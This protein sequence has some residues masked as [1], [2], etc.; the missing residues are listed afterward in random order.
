MSLFE[1]SCVYIRIKFIAPYK[2]WYFFQCKF[3]SVTFACI[4]IKKKRNSIVNFPFTAPIKWTGLRC[5]IHIHSKLALKIYDVKK[6]KKKKKKKK[7]AAKCVIFVILHFFFIFSYVS[8]PWPLDWRGAHVTPKKNNSPLR[9][10]YMSNSRVTQIKL[11][12]HSTIRI[13]PPHSLAGA[14]SR[15]IMKCW[16][17]I[18]F[19]LRRRRIFLS[20]AIC[21]GR[22]KPASAQDTQLPE[23][24]KS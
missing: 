2:R 7:L 11:Q 9:H 16:N 6:K 12:Q 20:K 10:V 23:G 19:P 3:V 4:Y 24:S 1:M 22:L 17:K 14:T 21:H 8:I 18:F 5:Y 15:C 13:P